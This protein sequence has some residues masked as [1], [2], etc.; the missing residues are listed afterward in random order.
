M[1]G[2][3]SGS[4]STGAAGGSNSGGA[5]RRCDRLGGSSALGS[6]APPRPLGLRELVALP[7][8]ERLLFLARDILR[9]GSVLA[10]ELEMLADGV[11]EESHGR[12]LPSAYSALT[13]RFLPDR[14]AR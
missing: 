3:P 8:A 6:A 7:G 12:R 5:P 2:S 14:F 9:I 4:S 10:L 1:P 13:V 11:V